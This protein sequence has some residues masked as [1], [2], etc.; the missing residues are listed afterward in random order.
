[1][2]AAV[3]LAAGSS[4][5]FG[6][7]KLSESLAGVPTWLKSFRA[8]AA[9]P[10]VDSVGVV[11]SAEMLDEIRSAV[12]QALFVVEGG[13]DRA[14]S[15]KIGVDQLPSGAE[16]VL[17]H[18]AARPWV[19]H[20]LITRVIEGVERTGAAVPGLPVTDT[21]KQV[22]GDQVSTLDRGTLRAVQTP[23][24]ARLNLIRDLSA[25]GVVTDDASLWEQ[26]GLAVEIVEGDPA[27]K[28]IT[29]EEDLE[30]KMEETR[31]GMGYDVHRFSKD[32][33]RPMILGGVEFD[34]RP[35]LEG[36][37]DADAL[38]HAVVDALLGAVAMGDIGEHFPNTD[39]R[40]KDKPSV[41]FLK[42]AGEMLAE[43]G[44]S[45]RHIDCSVIAERPKL[46]ARRE[47]MRQAISEPLGL[48][49]DQVS[50]KATTNEGLGSLGRGEGIAAFATATVY[51]SA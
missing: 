49:M 19:S 17:I 21:I 29:F 35:G 27:N 38:V 46:L 6:R 20:D 47:D 13:A 26:A 34:D 9:H 3:L 15:S 44:W 8:L 50:I 48:T 43:S 22:V 18:D 25:S 7:N 36:H 42:F 31:T 40:W 30:Q 33:D 14:A 11:C 37:S 4:A 10:Q 28:K 45:I 24:G 41:H 2:I 12:P 32:P 16:I 5:R 23:Q 39:P 1:M 51:R